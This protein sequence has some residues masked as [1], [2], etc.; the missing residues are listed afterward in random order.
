MIIRPAYD[1]LATMRLST[2]L[3]ALLASMSSYAADLSKQLIKQ[4]RCAER[5]EHLFGGFS[6]ELFSSVIRV[7]PG[8]SGN[9]DA[10]IVDG[11]RTTLRAV[12]IAADGGDTILLEDGEYTIPKAKKGRSTGLHVKYSNLTVRSASGNPEK[13][14]LNGQYNDLGYGSGLITVDAPGFTIADV[15]L[16]KSLTHLLHVHQN[17]D[18]FKAHN[19]R[20]LD[21]SQQFLKASANEPYQTI[22][23]AEITCSAFIMTATGREN[24]WG[25]GAQDGWTR[26]YTGGIDAHRASDWWIANNKFEGIYCDTNTPHP[27]HGHT[28]QKYLGGLAEHAIHLWHSDD[29][30]EHLIE[31]NQIDSCARGIG[32]GQG[33]NPQPGSAIIQSN[34][35]ISKFAGSQEHDVAIIVEALNQATIRN[36]TI[37]Y[38]HLHAYPFGIEYRFESTHAVIEGNVMTN[39]IRPRDGAIGNE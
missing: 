18:E 36:N 33:N 31:R 12:L 10:V 32:V 1:S 9:I 19:V 5:S 35:I 7:A 34:T 30:S 15:T 3:F 14:I 20:F 29:D 16:T 39:R 23:Q 13:V 28:K 6:P 38:A 27:Q 21:A 8:G 26:C 17:G 24:V 2:F 25:Y 37:I 11:E 4:D 22:R